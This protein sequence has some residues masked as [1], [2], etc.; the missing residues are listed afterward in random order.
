MRI[1][2]YPTLLILKDPG[3]SIV[4]RRTFRIVIGDFCW[5]KHKI[6]IEQ[7]LRRGLLVCDFFIYG[8][9]PLEIVKGL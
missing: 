4:V 5:T 2:S 3:S 6:A 1:Y 7:P 9:E 8:R